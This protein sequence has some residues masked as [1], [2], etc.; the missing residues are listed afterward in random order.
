MK[1]NAQVLLR[2]LTEFHRQV[3]DSF[4]EQGKPAL[5]LGNPV[6]RTFNAYLNQMKEMFPDSFI[7]QL[8]PVESVPEF[9]ET[10]LAPVELEKLHLSRAHE[11]S[12]ECSQIIEYLTGILNGEA[13]FSKTTRRLP[14]IL[15]VLDTLRQ[16]IQGV[17]LTDGEEDKRVTEMLVGKYNDCLSVCHETVGEGDTILPRLF[18]PIEFTDDELSCAMKIQE[19]KISSSGLHA[20]LEALEQQEAALKKQRNVPL[21]GITLELSRMRD[22]MDTKDK[23][24]RSEFEDVRQKTEE[25]K[26]QAFEK[27]DERIENVEVQFEE[28][29]QRLEERMDEM[30]E[31]IGEL[32]DHFNEIVDERSNRFDERVE[33]LE[34]NLNERIEGLEEKHNNELENLLEEAHRKIEEFEEKL[35]HSEDKCS[36]RIDGIDE[37][38]EEVNQRL[39]ETNES[40]EGNID[41]K[42]HHLEEQLDERLGELDEKFDELNERIDELAEKLD[43]KANELSEEREEAKDEL[44]E[45]IDQRIEELKEKIDE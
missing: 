15:A 31:K 17:K 12:M 9:G 36:E 10:E 41:D 45:E 21:H 33:H 27:I 38:L 39:D 40:M 20:Y 7:A 23:R 13:G 4:G 24:I 42:I 30:N 26:E 8:P 35:S 16:E 19:V 11:V 18:K 22:W 28:R 32:K 6:V 2:M 34:E 3:Q 1:E 43:E 44:R 29:V 37:K 14:E 25:T 5:L